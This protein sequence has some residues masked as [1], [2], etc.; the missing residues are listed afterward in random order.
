MINE[1]K[2]Q[3]VVSY[4]K[5]G[6]KAKN[7]LQI[8]IEVEHFVLNSQMESISYE[9][10]AKVIKEMMTDTDTLFEEEGALLGYYNDDFSISLEPAAQL[11]ISIMPQK[12]MKKLEEILTDFYEAYGKK[13]EAIGYHMETWGYH[14]AKKAEQLSLIPK[15]RYEFMDRYFQKSGKHGRNMMRAT[16]STQVSIDFISEQDFVEKYRL[17]VALIPILSLITDNA[18]IYEGQPYQG[19]LIRT[20]IWKDVDP[21]RC[22]I[23]ENCFEDDFGFESYARDI[24]NKPLILVK[25]NQ[26]T[27]FTEEKTALEYYQERQLQEDEIEHIVSMFFPDIRLKKYLEIRMA[28]SLPQELAIAYAQL[29]WGIFYHKKVQRAL[30]NSLEVKTIR[31]IDEAKDS[32]MEKGYEGMVYGKPVRE[33]IRALFDMVLEELDESDRERLSPLQKKVEKEMNAEK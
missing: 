2:V 22:Q 11:E 9:E 28:D 12:D 19:H 14:P 8:G 18:K 7:E 29:I 26:E 30:Q 23:Q 32:L 4:F 27:V 3:R 33:V 20:M 17:L 31:E 6:C 10:I 15:K 13:L 24:L 16:A 1:E 25:E 5:S 21:I